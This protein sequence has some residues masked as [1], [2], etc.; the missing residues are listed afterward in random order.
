M[1]GMNVVSFFIY[2]SQKKTQ[3]ISF[4]IL[5]LVSFPTTNIDN[6]VLMRNI[7]M[8]VLEYQVFSANRYIEVF[9]DEKAYSFTYYLKF[10]SYGMLSGSQTIE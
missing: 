9:V 4:I 1:A 8:P 3:R 10:S 7:Q 5:I 6:F 2:C